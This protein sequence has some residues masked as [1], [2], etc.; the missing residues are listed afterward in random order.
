MHWKY[1]WIYI[2]HVNKFYVYIH[3]ANINII[4]PGS[5]FIS[6][7]TNCYL[8]RN[9]LLKAKKNMHLKKDVASTLLKWSLRIKA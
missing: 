7:Y 6:L 9:S 5:Q 3:I 1:L 2:T 8:K 4:K